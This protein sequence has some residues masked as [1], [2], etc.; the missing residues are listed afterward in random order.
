M[1]ESNET[2]LVKLTN[3]PAGVYVSKDIAT[4]TITNDD[5]LV[6]ISTPNPIVEGNLGASGCGHGFQRGD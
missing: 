4:G 1:G 5:P 2:F 6:A 3:I